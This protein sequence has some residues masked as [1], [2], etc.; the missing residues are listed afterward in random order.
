MLPAIGQVEDFTRTALH[1]FGHALGLDHPDDFDQ[2]VAA[3]MNSKA[4]NV[5]RLQ[6]DDRD[7][8]HAVDYVPSPIDFQIDFTPQSQA[9]HLGNTAEFILSATIPSQAETQFINLVSLTGTCPPEATCNFTSLELTSAAPVTY[10]V[11]TTTDTVTGEYPLLII[12]TAGG[13]TRLA[14]STLTISTDEDEVQARVFVT[15]EDD[16]GEPIAQA[17]IRVKHQ[18]TKEKIKGV[19]DENGEYVSPLLEPAEYK[20]ICKKAGFQ[21]D[22]EVITLAA[23]DEQT[24]NC[25]LEPLAAEE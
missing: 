16:Q 24:V 10:S 15:V 18:I 22:K 11:I 14:T 25:I 12:G 7:G 13:I 3:I 17:K 20:V 23:G 4:T 19:T 21:K 6:P 8:A 5:D 2:I 1:E 9:I